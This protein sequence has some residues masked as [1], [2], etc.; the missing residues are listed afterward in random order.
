MFWRLLRR[1]LDQWRGRPLDLWWRDDDARAPSDALRRLIAL[2]ER[3]GAPVTLAVIPD[4]DR[5]DL[6]RLLEDA[7]LASVIQHGVDHVNRGP[8]DRPHEFED[9]AAA[10]TIAGRIESGWARLADLPRAAKVF[11]PPWNTAAPSLA[12]ALGLARYV[13]WS[14]YDDMTLAGAPTG[15]NAHLDVLRWGGGARFRG[16]ARALNRLIR[17]I[18]ERRL[19]GAWD[20]PVGLLTHHLDH[21]EATWAFLARLLEEVGRGGVRWRSAQELWG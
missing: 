4:G 6:G 11:A 20:A 16:K 8:A 17:L 15:V 9:G 12:G 7:P 3:H 21:D 13:G 19:A 2:S 14:G 1:E 5:S 10:E 18:R